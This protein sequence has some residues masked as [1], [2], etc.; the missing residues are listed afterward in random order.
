MLSFFLLFFKIVIS[1]L[2]ADSSAVI[3]VKS[4][5]LSLNAHHHVHKSC[6]FLTFRLLR[7]GVQQLGSS[8]LGAPLTTKI[9]IIVGV[10]VIM[11][12]WFK[13][14]FVRNLA[15]FIFLSQGLNY[16]QSSITCISFEYYYDTDWPIEDR[17][18]PALSLKIQF[19]QHSKHVGFC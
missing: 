3:P 15:Q 11:F 7:R 18:S 14:K 1:Y 12:T 9:T 5:L 16:V 6:V 2:S 4:K 10:L 17:I 13:R 19:V 8:P